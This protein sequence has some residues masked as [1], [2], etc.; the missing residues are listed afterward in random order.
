M[1]YCKGRKQA[2]EGNNGGL[3]Y[4]R[5]FVTPQDRLTFPCS[6]M[7]FSLTTITIIIIIIIIVRLV[8]VLVLVLLVLVLGLGLGKT[9]VIG[10]ASPLT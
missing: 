9:G 10:V 5:L 4:S 2:K 6:G 1:Q 3:W 7:F 8:L